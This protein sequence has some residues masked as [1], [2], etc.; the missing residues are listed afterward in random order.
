V[1]LQSLLQLFS[2]FLGLVFAALDNA[3]LRVFMPL[4]D[5]D[6]IREHFTFSPR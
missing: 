6:E 4:R 3:L 5:E 1:P 2:R